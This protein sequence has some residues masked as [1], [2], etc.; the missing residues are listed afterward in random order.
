MNPLVLFL[1][2]Y[3]ASATAF[4]AGL[5][6]FAVIDLV[7]I[8]YGLGPVPVWLG[9][10]AIWFF[11]LSLFIN[12]RRH[13][14]RGVGLAVLPVGLAIVSKGIGAMV[15]LM[16][17]IY[18]SMVDFAAD[19]GVDTSDQQ[20]MAQAFNDPGF[21]QEFQRFLQD[22]PDRVEQL[23]G[24]T[25]LASFIGFWLVIVLFALWFARLPRRAG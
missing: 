4:L 9:M 2:V 8:Q 23:L 1:P 16:P 25:G 7:R 11:V 21:Q 5:A 18:R 3:R 15:G 14:G 6:L 24:A 12:R 20:E 10:L 17:A 22:N 13:A 19:N